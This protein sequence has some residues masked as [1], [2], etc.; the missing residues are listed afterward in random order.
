MMNWCRFTI[1][2][3]ALMSAFGGARAATLEVPELIGT[4]LINRTSTQNFSSFGDFALDGPGM[5]AVSARVTGKPLPSIAVSAQ[6]GDSEFALLYGRAVAILRYV[7][8]IT[9]PE[10]LVPVDIGVA[11]HAA[12]VADT[13]AS[14]VVQSSWQLVDSNGSGPVLAADD[15]STPQRSGSFSES[16]GRTVSV[17]LQSNRLYL[18]EL[19]ADAQAAASEV[20]SSATANAFIDPFFSFGAGVDTSLFA[21]HFTSGIG[22]VAPVPLPLPLA[23]FGV[24]IAALGWRR[25]R[26]R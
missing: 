4:V 26:A 12:G 20:G 3:S 11:G 9:G 19:R 5:G 13:G 1:L 7:V 10:A 2:I 24:A 25:R 23:T 8:Q 21:F 18:V 16:F 14:F 15:I 17:N 22:N 6:M